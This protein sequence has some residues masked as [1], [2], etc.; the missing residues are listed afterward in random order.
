M[1]ELG[2]VE[3]VAEMTGR[4]GR[5]IKKASGEVMYEKRNANGISMTMQVRTRGGA[6][7]RGRGYS[8]FH[9]FNGWRAEEDK[10][11]S[12]KM[13]LETVKREVDSSECAGEEQGS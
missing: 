2:G 13:F 5:M 10:R 9:H 11:P 7:G 8:C 6:H 1:N 3:K 4:K 12:C